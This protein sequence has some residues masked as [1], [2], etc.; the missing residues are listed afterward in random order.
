VSWWFLG[1]WIIPESLPAVNGPDPEITDSHNLEND[2]T[3]RAGIYRILRLG[4]EIE[5]R[6]G[7]IVWAR[8]DDNPG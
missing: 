3:G 2:Q 1:I 6:I 7:S 8:F 5:D 4:G